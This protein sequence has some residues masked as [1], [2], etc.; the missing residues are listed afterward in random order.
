MHGKPAST[1][2][3]RPKHPRLARRQALSLGAAGVAGALGLSLR[4]HAATPP[5]A[6]A[7]APALAA[8]LARFTA[9]ATVR[10]GRVQ[11]DLPE[12]VENG[13]AVP[14]TVSVPGPHPTG[15]HVLALALFAGRN[16]LPEVAVFTLAGTPGPARVSTRIRLA[17]SQPVVAAARLAD[18]SVWTRRVDVLVTLAAC[19]EG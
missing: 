11:L 17:T 4:V 18:G 1:P 13:N 3:L 6:P 16:P 5:Q 14:V 9:G 8:A 12:L 2:A 10:E 7:L 19:I 15:Q